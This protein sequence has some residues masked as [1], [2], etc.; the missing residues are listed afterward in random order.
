MLEKQ[1]LGE[2]NIIRRKAEKMNQAVYGITIKMC[3]KYFIF[4]VIPHIT[5]LSNYP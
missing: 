5:F 3:W 1:H 2:L 4:A